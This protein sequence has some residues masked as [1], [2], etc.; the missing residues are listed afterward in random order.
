ARV[1]PVL[2]RVD[3]VAESPRRSTDIHDPQELRRRAFGALR[4]LFARIGDRKPLALAID[5]LQWGDV[6]SA[7]LLCDLLPPPEAP[8]FLLVCTYRSEYVP[9]SPCLRMLRDPAVSGLPPDRRREVVV[10]A[11][12]AEESCELALKLLG[13]EDELA[14]KQAEMIARESGGSPYFIY[15][16]VEHLNAGGELE[17]RSS[18]AGSIALDEVLWAR[19]RRLPEDARALLEVLAV[20]G[21]PLRQ[22]DAGRAAGLGPEGFEALA[23]LRSNHLVRG[24]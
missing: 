15:E 2:R 3:A 16:L 8:L 23:S 17:D 12:S 14:R 1:F 6:D 22:A 9:H 13:H 4:E 5:D 18:V 20:A 24:T 10:D 19:I 11:L 7:A 21:Q